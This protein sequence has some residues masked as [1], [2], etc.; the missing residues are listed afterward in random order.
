MGKG[1]TGSADF[2][3]PADDP[4]VGPGTSAKAFVAF[5]AESGNEYLISIP[6][7]LLRRIG[8]AGAR[9]GLGRP[10]ISTP[11]SPETRSTDPTR[12]ANA[13]DPLLYRASWSGGVDNRTR[14]S[15]L[16]SGTDRWVWRAI[17]DLGGCTA[18][19]VGPRHAITAGHCIY[20]R[21]KKT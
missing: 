7:A 6:P 19:L 14:L 1:R 18:T 2:S 20:N 15:S 4:A 13:A 9:A 3:E 21:T 5:N 8:D 16:T 11:A 12:D 17:A 10:G